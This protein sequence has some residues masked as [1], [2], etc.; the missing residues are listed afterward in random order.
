MTR[1]WNTGSTHLPGLGEEMSSRRGGRTATGKSVLPAKGD[2]VDRAGCW[3]RWRKIR[4][5][6]CPFS[7]AAG[8]SPETLTR[9]ICAGWRWGEVQ[10]QRKTQLVPRVLA[11]K[12][13]G[14]LG[15]QGR[16]GGVS[17]V[18]TERDISTSIGKI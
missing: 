8:R 7:S 4:P 10:G 17:L 6:R 13:S 15:S 1:L 11:L 12:G 5:E 14:D 3:P 16:V 18:H 2:A 9:A